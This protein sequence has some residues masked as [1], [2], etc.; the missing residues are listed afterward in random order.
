MHDCIVSILTDF[1][2]DMSDNIK[3]AE[4]ARKERW[5]V[6]VTESNFQYILDSVTPQQGKAAFGIKI[7]NALLLRWHNCL[8]NTKT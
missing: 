5:E 7:A 8:S 4:I 2:I 1:S 6:S 3:P